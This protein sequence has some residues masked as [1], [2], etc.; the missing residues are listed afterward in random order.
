MTDEQL[1]AFGRGYHA[2]YSVGEG[3]YDE[4]KR[5]DEEE[6]RKLFQRGYDVGAFDYQDETDGGFGR[7]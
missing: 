7:D 3:R 1:R 5:E 6:L 4:Y 2:G